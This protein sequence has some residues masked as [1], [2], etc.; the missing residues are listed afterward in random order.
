MPSLQFGVSYFFLSKSEL[1]I[2]PYDASHLIRIIKLSVPNCIS[3]S[4]EKKY[5]TFVFVIDLF[6]FLVSFVFCLFFFP[7][8]YC[9][10]R[11]FE[12]L[13]PMCLV[14]LESSKH[15]VLCLLASALHVDLSGTALDLM[16]FSRDPHGKSV[17]DLHSSPALHCI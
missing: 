5:A 15:K 16:F 17:V 2:F 7:T 3:F 13:P 9:L 6:S 1:L 8:L 4:N 10:N 11:E 14:H 12:V